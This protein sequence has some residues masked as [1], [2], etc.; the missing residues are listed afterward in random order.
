MN[1]FLSCFKFI[2]M[3]YLFLLLFLPLFSIAQEGFPNTIEKDEKSISPKATLDDV[4]WMA[5]HWKGEAFGGVT[6]EI[7]SPKLGG[8]MMGSFKLVVEDEI[9]F[10]ELMTITEE[11]GSLMLRIKHFDKGL[12]GWEEKDVS[13]EFTLLKITDK[14]IY[15]DGLTLEKAGKKSIVIYVIIDEKG[16][17]EE[18]PFA[19]KRRGKLKF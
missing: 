5:G 14:K 1:D 19:Y 9:Q 11:N 3:K 2:V 12:N 13:E 18:V 17:K 8:S 16:K 6:E 4:A 15:F 10:Y 7:W